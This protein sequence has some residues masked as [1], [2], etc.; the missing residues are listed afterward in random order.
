M[1][2]PSGSQ[3]SLSDVQSEIGHVEGSSVTLSIYNKA[4]KSPLPK[5]TAGLDW[6]NLAQQNRRYREEQ[7]G[8][9]VAEATA[10][11]EELRIAME[12]D[13]MPTVPL[14]TSRAVQ[15]M[16]KAG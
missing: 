7:Q 4:L 6:Q 15:A 2:H 16:R 11:E 3:V 9:A 10:A 12:A 14:L 5:A 13:T 1:I 8:L